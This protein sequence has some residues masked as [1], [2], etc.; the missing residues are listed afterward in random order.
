MHP[1]KQ[2]VKPNPPKITCRLKF[3][4]IAKQLSLALNLRNNLGFGL[5]GLDK[6]FFQIKP[7]LVHSEKKNIKNHHV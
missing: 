2:K 6:F 3:C 5:E 4:E 1:K 7:I